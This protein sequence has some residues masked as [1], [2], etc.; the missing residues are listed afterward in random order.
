M[1][2]RLTA[3]G[4]EAERTASTLPPFAEKTA[5]VSPEKEKNKRRIAAV[6]PA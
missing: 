5:A 3:A 1:Q 4:A 6:V 2:R